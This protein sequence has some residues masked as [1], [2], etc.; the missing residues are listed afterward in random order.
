[1]STIRMFVIA[2]AFEH[3]WYRDVAN[4]PSSALR[5]P[6]PGGR[7]KCEGGFVN[8]DCRNTPFS[9]REKVPA[10]R[11]RGTSHGEKF[12]PTS[13]ERC[14]YRCAAAVDV[15]GANRQAT[16][17]GRLRS[18]QVVRCATALVS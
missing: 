14:R 15:T 3:A 8:T 13:V 6:S 4:R 5:A 18:V 10:G 17:P 16:L 11:M 9:R 1:M 2:A 12:H 7:R